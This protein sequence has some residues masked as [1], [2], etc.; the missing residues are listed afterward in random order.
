M[1][2][3]KSN[4]TLYIVLAIVGVLVV[5]GGIILAVTLSKDEPVV[6]VTDQTNEGTTNQPPANTYLPPIQQPPAKTDG[7][8]PLNVSGGSTGLNPSS[9]GSGGT[10]GI[11]GA[12]STG[13]TPDIRGR[14]TEQV[15][16][17]GGRSEAVGDSD[18]L[19]GLPTMKL[20]PLSLERLVKGLEHLEDTSPELKSEIDK[21]C[22]TLVDFHAGRAYITAQNRL[23]EIGKPAIPMMIAAFLK[24]GDLSSEQGMTNAC[25]VDEALRMTAGMPTGMMELRPMANPQKNQIERTAKGWAVWWFAKGHEMTSFGD[26]DDEEEE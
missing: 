2:P 1:P 20:R 21:L 25:V 5:G 8:Q 9:S 22:A 12:A 17:G 16:P 3:P 10:S 15:N 23:A 11:G 24:A 13:N 26:E 19:T 18:K 4:A 14:G 7:A 6:I